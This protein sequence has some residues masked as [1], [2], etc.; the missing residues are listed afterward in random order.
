MASSQSPLLLHVT[1][2]FGSLDISSKIAQFLNINTILCVLKCLDKGWQQQI[3]AHP[4]RFL[5]DG[6]LV[7]LVT[8]PGFRSV[9]QYVKTLISP[10]SIIP[11]GTWPRV[12]CVRLS[13]FW[14]WEVELLNP[15]DLQI[16][17]NSLVGHMLRRIPYT[18][19]TRLTLHLRNWDDLGTL[20]AHE[21]FLNE[22]S[23]WLE[24]VS[25][26]LGP[27]I[28]QARA[29]KNGEVPD[30]YRRLLDVVTHFQGLMLLR[31]FPNIFQEFP[32][33]TCM[34]LPHN[35]Y[36]ILHTAQWPKHPVITFQTPSQYEQECKTQKMKRLWHTR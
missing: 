10:N 19:K 30:V 6:E 27:E 28:K 5:L 32:M 17:C 16:H 3:T 25:I 23:V 15:L 12:Q 36:P 2:C 1:R 33:F 14:G 11:G 9:I 13:V 4:S 18:A 35:Y 20:L 21:Y 34:P 8:R 31:R 24:Q 29:W 7:V 22:A 26:E